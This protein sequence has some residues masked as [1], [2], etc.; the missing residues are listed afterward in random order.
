M[1]TPVLDWMNFTA[2]GGRCCAFTVNTTPPLTAPTP[3]RSPTALQAQTVPRHEGKHTSSQT[4][5]HLPLLENTAGRQ[6]LVMRPVPLN[7]APVNHCLLI[8]IMKQKAEKIEILFLACTTQA[9][10]LLIFYFR[11]LPFDVTQFAQN[12]SKLWH[13]TGQIRCSSLFYYFFFLNSTAHSIL[14]SYISLKKV[15]F[16]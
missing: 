14:Y 10:T 6:L 1:R 8:K 13:H 11:W 5:H 2:L 7:F 15:L 12:T 9:L 16:L 3:A 4:L